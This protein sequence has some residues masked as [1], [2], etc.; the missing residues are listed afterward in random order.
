MFYKQRLE[1]PK[2][3]ILRYLTLRMN[4]SEK[5]RD[6]YLNLE[7]GF[8]GE[9]VFDLLLEK[10]SKEYLILNDLLLENNNSI[11]Q[12]DS[13]LISR[14]IIYIFEIKNYEGDYYIEDRKWY[15]KYKKEMKNP[16]LQLE[17]NDS[18]FRRLLQDLG[19][20]FLIES[21]VVFVNPSFY[22][23]QAPMNPH[24]IFPT[25]LTR[26]I[27]NLN[28]N[29]FQLKDKNFKLAKQLV[30]LHLKENP[31]SKLPNYSFGFLKKGIPCFYC[32]TF[33]DYFKRDGLVCKNCGCKEDVTSAVLRNIEEFKI[34]FPDQLITTKVIHEWCQVVSKKAILRI[35]SK[36]F[37]PMGNRKSTHYI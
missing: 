28:K 34:L 2:L 19:F 1:T 21:N 25:Q 33:F 8:K 20:T 13:L 18:L 11:F 30:S 23:Y 12:I 6:E 10:L 27:E 29:T 3:K 26:L 7:K 9:Q 14:D 35:L 15:S 37:K 36:N 22:L 31:Y 16:L 17:R 4:F 5:Q 32:G 24:L